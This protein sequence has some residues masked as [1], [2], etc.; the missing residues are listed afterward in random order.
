MAT[1]NSTDYSRTRDQIITD[2]FIILGVYGTSDTVSANDI[3]FASNRLN[4]MIKGWESKGIH[5]W[6]EQEGAIFLTDDQQSY[7][8]SSSSADICGDDPRFTT[9]TANSSSSTLV[10][11]STVGM[12]AA[13]NIGVVL[14]AGTLHWTT[15]VSVDSTTGLTI[16]ST[17][18]SIASSGNNVFTFTNRIDK[19]L[20]IKSARYR[21]SDGTE[22]PIT[23]KG[24][25]GFMNLPDKTATGP[26]TVIYY[27]PKVSTATA[28]VWPVCEDVGECIR[29]SYTRRIQ[30]F[31]SSSN[32]PDFPQECYEAATYNLS[33]RLAP[34][35]GIDTQKLNP[36][37]KEIAQQA[38]IDMM[39]WDIEEGSTHIVPNYRYDD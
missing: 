36:D 39:M 34:A 11:D 1:S 15:I 3:S 12:T 4:E 25:V 22:R 10:V 32:T 16:T 33:I 2:A 7:S 17:L 35:Y 37:I 30:D 5:L 18:P 14:D 24:R 9:L 6:T 29:I 19:P 8:L 27:S 28:Y 31:D 38:M 23:K 20:L 13:D 21:Y 26:A